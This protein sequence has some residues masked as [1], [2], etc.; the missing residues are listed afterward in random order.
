MDD[1]DGNNDGRCEGSQLGDDGIGVWADA[2]VVVVV[3]D[4][5]HGGREQRHAAWI[6]RR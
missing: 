4:E 1:V 3:V 5:D 6:E 2:N